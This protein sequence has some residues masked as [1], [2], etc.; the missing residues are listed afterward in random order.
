VAPFCA[1]HA[2]VERHGGAVQLVGVSFGACPAEAEGHAGHILGG[3]SEHG[4]VPPQPLAHP[5]PLGQDAI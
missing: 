4:G 1:P 2:P 3:G 5:G